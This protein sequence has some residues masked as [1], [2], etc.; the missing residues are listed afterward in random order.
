MDVAE[1]GAPEGKK[2]TR[3]LLRN[4]YRYSSPCHLF[5]L[6]ISRD[7]LIFHENNEGQS[8]ETACV[9]HAVCTCSG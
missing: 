5:F 8:S 4:E 7:E 1:V 9:E 3:L 2:V 6:P